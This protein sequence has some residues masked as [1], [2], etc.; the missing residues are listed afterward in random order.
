M[1]EENTLP[2][3]KGGAG[4]SPDGTPAGCALLFATPGNGCK[5]CSLPFRGKSALFFAH[6]GPG[7]CAAAARS[8]FFKGKT[9]YRLAR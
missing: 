4:S 3:W 5:A 1:R 9:R 8:P 6:F 2:S 7:A